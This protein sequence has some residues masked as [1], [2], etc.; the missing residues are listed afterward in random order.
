[1]ANLELKKIGSVK[2]WPPVFLRQPGKLILTDVQ[3]VATLSHTRSSQLCS[4]PLTLNHKLYPTIISLVYAIAIVTATGASAQQ[5]EYDESPRGSYS[6]RSGGFGGR[7]GPAFGGGFTGIAQPEQNPTQNSYGAP[8][9]TMQKLERQL[10]A[11]DRPQSWPKTSPPQMQQMSSP[12]PS[13]RQEMLRTFFGSSSGSTNSGS[14]VPGG[15]ATRQAYSY[16]QTAANQAR[17]AYNYSQQARYNRD[18]WTR[19]K[20]CVISRICSRGSESAAKSAYQISLS[21][22]SNAQGYA[23]QARAAANRARA[24]ANRARYNANTIRSS[25]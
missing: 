25:N 6:G 9:G 2:K 4:L 18:S 17:K 22:D 5:P 14:A 23:S 10:N 13:V 15:S 8:Q 12:S 24:D 3:A 16:Y 11:I 1:M 21:G 20:R 7:V 19:K